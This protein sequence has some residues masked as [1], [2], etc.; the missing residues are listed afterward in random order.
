MTAKIGEYLAASPDDTDILVTPKHYFYPLSNQIRSQLNF[1][2]YK[3]ILDQQ[4]SSSSRQF[5]EVY[6]CHLWS[7]SWLPKPK[8]KVEVKKAAVEKIS[9]FLSDDLDDID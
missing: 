7:V 2:T 8:D 3:A 9:K 5:D 4:Y 1:D 6:T